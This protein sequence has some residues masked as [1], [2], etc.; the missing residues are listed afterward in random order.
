MSRDLRLCPGVGA[1]KCG[2]FLSSLD[3][4]PHPTCTRCRGKVCTRDLTCDICAEWS[5]AQWEAFAKKRSN[6]ERK[7]SCPS[8]SLPPAPKT[9]PRARTSSEVKHP[10]A[11]SSSLPSGGQ[12]KGWGSRDAPGAA[13]CGA[14]SP[15]ARL[16]SSER[17]GS[18]SGRSSYAHELASVSSAPLGVE[19]GGAARSQRTP[20]ARFASSVDSPRS[21]LHALRGGESG[22]PSEVRSRSRSSRV[23]RSSDRGTRKDRRARSRLDS[24]RGRSRRSRGQAVESIVGR[25]RLG[26]CPPASGCGLLT[27]I[28]LVALARCLAGIALGVIGRSLLPAT[29][30]DGSVRDPLLVREVAVT[31]SLAALV[32]AHGHGCGRLSPLTVRGLGIKASEPD[33]NSGRV[34]RQWLS[35]RLPLSQKRQPQLRLLLWGVLWLCFRLLCRISPGFS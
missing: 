1:R 30:H 9:S 13:S 34:W 26:R 33:V 8:G 29:A 27:A 7:R 3:R 28:G 14:N 5:S 32:T 22:E 12:A 23:S 21:S 16:R 6:A 19:E 11:A 18:A 4:D 2:A 25:T 31:G 20:L 35:P 24:S 10:E 15:P 17:G